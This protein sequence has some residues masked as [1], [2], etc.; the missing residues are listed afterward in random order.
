VDEARAVSGPLAAA[1]PSF[2]L[3]LH[4]V[5]LAGLVLVA[6]GWPIALAVAALRNRR[7]A[8]EP[9]RW[10]DV[11]VVVPTLDEE[12]F[13]AAKLDDLRG[14]LY[15]PERLRVLVVDG[16]SSDRTVERVRA[17]AGHGVELRV[18]EEA[19]C[20]ADQLASAFATLGEEIVVVSDADTTL[21]PLCIRRLVATLCADPGTALVGAW[22]EPGTECLEE[23][24]HWQL[25]NALWWLE[26]EAA[27]A[28]GVSGVCYAVRRKALGDALAADA[29]AEDVQL[30]LALAA[31]GY[32]ARICRHARARELRVPRDAR[33][34]LAFRRR[35]GAAYLRELRRAPGAPVLRAAE[36][37]RR[38]RLALFA[39]GPRAALAAVLLLAALLASERGLAALA[40]TAVAAA[41]CAIPLVA[42]GIAAGGG[43]RPL[44]LA[45]ALA[46]LPF[47]TALALFSL[48]RAARLEGAPRGARR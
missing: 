41:I 17:A 15:P 1:L 7:P 14:T 19:R 43:R 6:V 45:V 35:R 40:A 22:V 26:G 21:D 5:V 28:T 8:A 24:I 2:L 36:I 9:A 48:P 31:Y 18:V 37:V 47:L 23:R 10:P 12:T 11:A 39:F 30:P 25:V 38:A 46:R 27:S 16:G 20:K 32:R 44:R 13:V 33:E 29:I 4:L 34:L 42:A 3:V